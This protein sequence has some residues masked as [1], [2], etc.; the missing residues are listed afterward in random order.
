[1][2][3]WPIQQHYDLSSD[4]FCNHSN[5]SLDVIKSENFFDQMNNYELLKT[6]IMNLVETTQGYVNYPDWAVSLRVFISRS[7]GQSGNP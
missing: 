1:V 7:I 5:T 6:C 3:V 2:R 4:G